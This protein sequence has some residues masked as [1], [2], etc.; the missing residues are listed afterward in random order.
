MEILKDKA[1]KNYDSL[2]RFTGF[3]TYY[4]TKDG[5]YV[6]GLLSQL[7]TDGEYVAH[8]VAETDTLESIAFKYYGR[9]DYY[10]VI[11]M[12]NKINDSFMKLSDS[13]E[14]IEVP[15]ISDISFK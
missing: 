14:I 9:P 13:F 1:Y 3:P 15:V 10:W 2:S 12:F 7:K 6:Y 8:K 5:K 11:A 4:N